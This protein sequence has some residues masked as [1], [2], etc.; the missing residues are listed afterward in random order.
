MQE[1]PFSLQEVFKEMFMLQ[2]KNHFKKV[3][4]YPS[5]LGLNL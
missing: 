2:E 5:G 4:L 3:I 1:R